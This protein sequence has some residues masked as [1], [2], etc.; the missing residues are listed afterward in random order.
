MSSR[1]APA[2]LI[3]CL[4]LGV[5][6]A[7]AQDKPNAEGWF[8]VD[9]KFVPWTKGRSKEGYEHLPF[10]CPGSLSSGQ[11][12]QSGQEQYLP[13]GG[14]PGVRITTLETSMEID[15]NG[16]G[17]V[18]AK[19]KGKDSCIP[20]RLTDK[21]GGA[22]DYLVRI[23]RVETSGSTIDWVFQ[24]SCYTEGT[25]DKTKIRLIDDNSDGIYGQTGRDAIA[26]GNAADHAVPLGALVN[27]NQKIYQIKVNASGSKI[28]LKPYEGETGKIDATKG[29]STLGK[30]VWAVFK[31]KDSWFDCAV[32]SGDTAFVVPV[33]SYRLDMG[34]VYNRPQGARIKGGRMKEVEVRK[35]QTS[36]V[37]WGGPL[38]INFSY[39][40]EGRILKIQPHQIEA[41]GKGG[42]VYWRFEPED[43]T[44][45]VHIRNKESK[46]VVHK[47]NIIL[48]G[49]PR[50]YDPA[51]WMWR[52][53]YSEQVKNEEGPF[54]V[55]LDEDQ[56]GKLFPGLIIGDWK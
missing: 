19:A 9:M 46:K 11:E 38:K 44:P 51:W 10:T 16:D 49:D 14:S 41:E 12:S 5:L 56:F 54:E 52:S 30:L 24:R 4:T 53:E 37:E 25:F 42:E 3:A 28:Q 29:Y 31:G 47:G 40:F 2:V 21:D 17:K 7:R 23:T 34:R 15:A 22:Y 36:Q 27:I 55:Y 1:L 45:R 8:E 43:M 35:D 13:I 32:S 50:T 6:P 33:G 48:R 18:D 20:L 39:N 26:I